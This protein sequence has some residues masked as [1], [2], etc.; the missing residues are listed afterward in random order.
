LLKQNAQPPPESVMRLILST[1]VMLAVGGCSPSP[2]D[3]AAAQLDNAAVQSD[4]AAA[5]I[6]ENAADRLRDDDSDANAAASAQNALSEAGSAQS[7]PSEG[8]TTQ[9]K[10]HAAGDPVPPPQVVR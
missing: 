5:E 8:S 1:F 10:P 9:A 7:A 3:N 6:L 2:A 4:P